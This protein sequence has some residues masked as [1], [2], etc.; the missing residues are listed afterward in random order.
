[1]GAV[2]PTTLL[3]AVCLFAL[4]AGAKGPDGDSHRA[5]NVVFILADDLGWAELGCYGN[6]FNETPHLDGLAR[7]GMRFSHAYAA[8][9]VCSPYRA[10][11]ISGQYPARVGITDYLRPDDPK[12]LATEHVTL[13]EM[14]KRA[15]YATGI[16]GKWHLT[17]YAHHGAV[18]VPPSE[19]GFDEVIVSEKRGIAGGSYYHPYHFNP[20]VTA[21]LPHEY[22]VDRMNLEAVEF[23]ERHR[24]RPFFL[25]L[26]HYAVH[27]ALVGKPDLVAKY[28][29]KPGAGKGPRAK[30]NN[31]HLAAQ[32]ESIDEGVGMILDKLDRLGLDDRTLVIFTSDNGGEDRVTSNAPLRAGKS[33]LYEG[34]IREPLVVRWPG[35][36]P[37]GTVCGTPV[38]CLDFYPTLVD[39]AGQA[40]D[41][42]Q[43]L[44]GLSI[45]P[46]L[47]DPKAKLP[48][49]ALYWHY[50][51]EKPHFLGGRSSGAIRHGDWKLIERFDTGELEL[52][53]LADDE[54]EQHNLADRMPERAAE[55][56]EKLRAWQKQVGAEVPEPMQR[57]E[58]TING[59]KLLFD[60]HGTVTVP[61]A[62]PATS[63]AVSTGSR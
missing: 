46:L 59:R 2:A 3:A 15:G 53:N 42:R 52:Y 44:D 14:L 13:A 4:P 12:H 17:G 24:A 16:I 56:R 57:T 29:A 8:A 31:P 10:G 20:A 62:S 7:Q 18:E 26:S 40:P 47:K 63:P 5:P 43:K 6:R 61:S 28:E 55:L 50:P 33:T 58:M 60:V 27:T 48:R 30:K 34:G 51:L 37:P 21:R 22:L 1:M 36:V 25:Y 19:H 32:L 41:P 23:I 11:F 35:V 54:G 45:L 38:W 39:A 9:P 49:D